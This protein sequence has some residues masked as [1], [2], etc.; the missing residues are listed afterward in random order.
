MMLNCKKDILM[1]TN[2]YEFTLQFCL[3]EQQSNK[4]L[5]IAVSFVLFCQFQH[6]NCQSLHSQATHRQNSHTNALLV[7]VSRHTVATILFLMT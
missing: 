4:M 1:L 7:I 6:V 5:S 3:S 2:Y